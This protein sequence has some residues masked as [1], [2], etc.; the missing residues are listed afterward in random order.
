MATNLWPNGMKCENAQKKIAHQISSHWMLY[1]CTIVIPAV[2]KSEYVIECTL[3]NLIAVCRQCIQYCKNQS[4]FSLLFSPGSES[5]SMRPNHNLINYQRNE[6]IRT[7]C[8][9]KLWVAWNFENFFRWYELCAGTKPHISNINF[10]IIT[11]IKL[12][13]AM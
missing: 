9:C 6:R 2:C 3:C 11:T 10:D 13:F 7:L 5:K 4:I 8:Q 1:K 12:C